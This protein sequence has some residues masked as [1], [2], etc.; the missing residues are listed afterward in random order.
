MSVRKS[1]LRIGILGH[2]FME[3]MG[4]VDFLANIMRGLACG[5]AHELYVL[6]PRSSTMI[7]RRAPA[8]LRKALRGIPGATSSIRSGLGLIA[9]IT[10]WMLRAKP[11]R[12]SGVQTDVDV[13][14]KSLPCEGAADAQMLA[15]QEAGLDVLLMAMHPLPGPVPYVTYWP[16][17]QSVHYPEFFEEA[18]RLTRDRQIGDLLDTRMPMI[19]NS[20]SV[21]ND[22]VKYY[23]GSEQRIFD[24]P[25]APMTNG[26][27]LNH[28]VPVTG[29]H[30][31]SAPY[32]IVCNQFWKHKSLETVVWALKQLSD[33]D[34]RAR[35]VFTGRM[36]DNRHPGYSQSVARLASDLK[37]E[38]RIEFL[39]YLPKDRQLALMKHSC[40][41]IQPTLFEGG[42]GG[43]STFDAVS[44]G[45]R[46]IVSDIPVNLELPVDGNR[47]VT[48]EARNAQDLADRM[49]KTLASPFVALSPA[50]L[51]SQSQRSAE[52]LHNRLNDAI[53]CALSHGRISA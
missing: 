52:L 3:N 14:L 19:V 18:A 25:F 43:G 17:C 40:A 30:D 16:D 15:A 39:G 53:S 37:L 28:T 34:I 35:V 36:E 22:M 27:S 2:R 42:P 7:E 44:I 38:D 11:S 45:V 49:A 47:I 13:R 48:F 51:E 5:N 24:L 6:T 9:P 1:R 46:V 33:Q 32:F 26:A 23:G 8:G 4:A 31:T 50:D 12:I 20:R 41:L 29:L 10:D 21:K